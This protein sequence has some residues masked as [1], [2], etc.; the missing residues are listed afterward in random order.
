MAGASPPSVIILPLIDIFDQR[1]FLLL[2]VFHR[3]H[4]TH[5]S[6]ISTKASVLPRVETRANS[7]LH[8]RPYRQM[9][10][11]HIYN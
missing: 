6:E 2:G 8:L 5:L 7:H 11:T 1:L 9:M 10:H 4:I 3:I